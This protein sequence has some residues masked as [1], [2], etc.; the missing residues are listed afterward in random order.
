MIFQNISVSGKIVGTIMG[1]KRCITIKI[2]PRFFRAGVRIE[3]TIVKNQE[4]VIY[5]EPTIE[6]DLGILREE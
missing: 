2:N 4:T 5:L 6:D 3:E 1:D